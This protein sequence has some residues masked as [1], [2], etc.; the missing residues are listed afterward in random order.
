M[1]TAPGVHRWLNLTAYDVDQATFT[2]PADIDWLSYD[3]YANDGGS[4]SFAHCM[5]TYAGYEYKSIDYYRGRLKELINKTPKS[6]PARAHP[7]GFLPPGAA[8]EQA[9]LLTRLASE[10]PM[11]ETDPT[12]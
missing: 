4:P 11:A 1:D 10:I 8:D 7:S 3:C 6:S 2:I 5:P 12:T 9:A